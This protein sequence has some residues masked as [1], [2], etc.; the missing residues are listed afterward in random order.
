MLMTPSISEEGRVFDDCLVASGDERLVSAAKSGDRSAFSELCN[1][2]ASKILGRVYRITRNWQ[3]AEDVLQEAML[4]AFVH[5]ND[6]ECRSG[7]SS[8]LTRI[9][10]NSALM[11]L[12]KRRC[13]E[14]S[15]DTTNHP[16]TGQTWEPW[17]L[18]PDPE[19]CYV[20]R[21]REEL[22]EGAILRLPPIFRDV[23]QMRHAQEYSPAEIAQTLGISLAAVKSR[24]S[25]AKIVLRASLQ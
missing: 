2:N 16:E 17:D 10:I 20:Q 11:M 21:E 6:F 8:W 1:R 4:K 23:I 19:S 18:R 14:V 5:L 24:L 13:V 22:L 3:D 9:A 25:R 7:F 15:I 12:R